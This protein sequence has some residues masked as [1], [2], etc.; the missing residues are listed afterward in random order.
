T[1]LAALTF[2]PEAFQAGASYYGVADLE[3]LTRD[4]HKFESRY[5]DSLIGPYPAMREVY[6]ARSPIHR[7]DRLSSPLIF[8][9]GLE[10][11]VVPPNQ[12]QIM[13]RAV[14]DKGLPVALLMFE[15]EQHGFRKAE[16]IVRSLEAELFFYGAVFGFVPAGH[17]PAFVIDNL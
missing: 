16:S 12:S 4:T 3:L 14:R 10:D 1:T 8:F 17:R 15:G 5:L 11:K 13:Q 2:R 9:Q 7:V 6:R